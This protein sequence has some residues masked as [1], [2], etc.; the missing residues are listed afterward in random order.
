MAKHSLH[1]TRIKRAVPSRKR[2]WAEKIQRHHQS[3][4]ARRNFYWFA[5]RDTKEHLTTLYRAAEK[6]Q[7]KV[8]DLCLQTAASRY[9]YEHYA[10]LPIYFSIVNISKKKNKLLAEYN[11]ATKNLKDA[12]SELGQTRTDI[13]KHTQNL[14][15]NQKEHEEAKREVK[16]LEEVMRRYDV[17]VMMA[18]P[19][20]TQGVSFL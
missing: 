19:P 4:V 12:Q 5:V 9:R 14:E 16:E 7:E 6:A 10:P 13:A 11:E 3:V 18:L 17:Q 20:K 15:E 2:I 1:F 8:K